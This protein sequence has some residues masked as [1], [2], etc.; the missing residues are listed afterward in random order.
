VIAVGPAAL[1]DVAVARAGAGAEGLGEVDAELRALRAAAMPA[2]ADGAVVRITARLGFDARVAL[3]AAVGVDV[4]PA[5][6]SVWADV[7]DDLAVIARLGAGAEAGAGAE[8]DARAEVAALREMAADALGAVAGLPAS[9]RLGVAPAV[10]AATLT[11]GDDGVAVIALIGPRRLARAVDR[12]R[13]ALPA[14]ATPPG[15]DDPA[16]ESP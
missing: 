9:R 3:A 15:A 8:T 13:A 7:A 14:A 16:L 11:A 10:R 5:T 4:A 6:L 1:V 12:A 2:Q